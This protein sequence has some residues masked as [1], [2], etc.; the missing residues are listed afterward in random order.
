L[1]FFIKSLNEEENEQQ[2]HGKSAKWK[3]F[4]SES[5]ILG[6]ELGNN[7]LVKFVTFNIS[8]FTRR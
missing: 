4:S 3:Q 7:S 8:A 2:I 1:Y 6:I 5:E